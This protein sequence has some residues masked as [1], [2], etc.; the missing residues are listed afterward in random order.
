MV[1]S[2]KRKL[3]G[4]FLRNRINNLINRSLSRGSFL[5]IALL[6]AMTGS[7]VL[8]GTLVLGIW[9]VNLETKESGIFNVAWEVLLRAMSP[10]QLSLNHNWSARIV[11]LAITLGG[12]LLV[13]T[14]ISILNSVIE[15]RMEF[16]HRGRGEVHLS[17]HIVVLNW[18]KFGLRVIREIANSA[19]PGHPP[20]QITV[21]CDEDPI[22][23]MHEIVAALASNGEL[24][25][26]S[27]H[28]RYMRH[29]EK[30]VTIRR[31]SATNTSDLTNLTSI[32]NA[33]SVIILQNQDDS[34][35]RTIRTVLAI[36]A[37]LAKNS[38]N[39]ISNKQDSLPVVTFVEHH[40]LATRLDARLS[41]IAKSAEKNR[42]YLNYIPLSPDDIRHGI[43][44][45]VSR[46][47]GL[48]A[49][50]QDLF[51][52]G[53]HELYI[54]DGNLIGG[55]FGEFLGQSEDA[56]PLCLMNDQ[57]INFWPNWDQELSHHH[58]VVLA[59][60][61]TLAHR[62][63]AT[64]STLQISGLRSNRQYIDLAPE[65]YLFVGWND[66]SLRLAEA[67]E[68]ILPN[69]SRLSIILRSNDELPIISNFS[70]STIQMFNNQ[71]PDQLDDAEF[72]ET[73]DHV[74]VF[75]DEKA[76][77]GESDATVL[78]D[79]VAC[80]HHVN[81][82]NDLERR[83]TVVAELRT[84]SSR[85]IA[86]VRLADDLLVNDSLMA[87]T[88]VQLAFT[89]ELEPI[90]MALLSIDDPVELVTRHVNKLGSD[91]VGKTWRDLVMK[92]AQETGEIAIGFRR[93]V[94]DE[95]EVVLNPSRTLMLQSQDEI[96]LLSQRLQ[97]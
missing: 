72:L 32:N 69:G 60:N 44:T 80:R 94:N 40:A 17:G 89:P 11:L 25:A 27:L 24:E 41:L 56:T 21:L 97:G 16:L 79:L 55:T 62:R 2:G 13:S 74:V 84:Q 43:E 48:S 51:N 20:R 54:V 10:D 83:F 39:S 50:Y 6:M 82:I 12:L 14:L 91:L 76:T 71:M 23:L 19:E 7:I 45:Q 9:H 53:G 49:V 81:Q 46:H 35:S 96:V 52:F 1:K 18:N 78:V 67:L 5:A 58:V 4:Q 30:W 22:S 88:A 57:G 47:R 33:H 59:E 90:F 36:D 65:N 66:S 3:S 85:Y 15:R 92:V 95:P 70:G 8:V 75:A 64:N 38:T 61:K 34:E 42:R 87:S 37:T 73:I 93:V 26:S 28:K 77:A 63:V 31:G 29:P 68:Q 86:G